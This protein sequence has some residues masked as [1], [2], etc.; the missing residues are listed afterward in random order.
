[1]PSLCVNVP[2]LHD[3]TRE[4][5]SFV[6]AYSHSRPFV[7][8]EVPSV[9]NDAGQPAAPPSPEPPSPPLD[10]VP[11]HASHAKPI[12]GTNNSHR[13]RMTGS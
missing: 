6:F 13:H 2:A 9:G 12:T 3:V 11:P 7:E 1:M 8:H 10:V 4:Q 5:N